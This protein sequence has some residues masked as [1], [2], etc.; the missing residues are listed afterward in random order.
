[1]VDCKGNPLK[2]GDSV[3]YIRRKT[4][5]ASLDTG[6]VTKI[7]VDR[8]GKEECSVGSQA[9]ISANRVLKINF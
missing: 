5:T 4:S 1:M 8:Y 6:T 9:H 2:V 7:Y 3:V